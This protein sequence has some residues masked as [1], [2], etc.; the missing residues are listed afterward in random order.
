MWLVRVLPDPRGRHLGC[1]VE[2][3]IAEK[4]DGPTAADNLAYACTFCNRAKG[5]DIGSIFA[6]T[7]EYTRFYHPRSDL[8]RDHFVLRG[9]RI[10]PLSAIGEVTARLLQF[11]HRDRL[12]ER[13]ALAAIGRYPSQAAV[14]Y[15]AY[16][17]T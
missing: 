7:G 8:W 15:V 6:L 9:T 4:H 14:L 5:T 16:Q 3:I 12:L 17:P 13:D 11:N 2:H 1:Q 10:E